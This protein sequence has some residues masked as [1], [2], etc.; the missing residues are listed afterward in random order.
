[1]PILL[2]ISIFR[3]STFSNHAIR[4]CLYPIGVKLICIANI[5]KAYLLGSDALSLST[6]NVATMVLPHIFRS[7]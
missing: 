5:E 3:E 6:L 1:M 4:N 7:F 2:S